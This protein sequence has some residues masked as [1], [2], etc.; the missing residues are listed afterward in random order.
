MRAIISASLLKSKHAQATAKPYD[1]RDTRLPGFILRVQPSGVRSYN[2]ETGRGKRVSVGKVGEYTPDEARD[3]AQRVIGN[4]AHDRP[5]LEGLEGTDAG[6]TLGEFIT[7]TY[8]PWQ[9]ANRP[10]G[11][12]YT[13]EVIRRYFKPWLAEPLSA[14]TV[15]RVEAWKTEK[16]SGGLKPATVLRGLASLSGCLSHA[17]RIGALEDNPLRKVVKPKL[18]RSPKVRYLDEAEEARLRAALAERDQRMRKAR[19]SA[20]TWRRARRQD[21][22]PTLKHFGDHLTPAVLISINTGLRRGELLALKWEDVDAKGKLVTVHGSG[23]KSGQTRHVPLN[24]E[25]LAAFK[26]W[27]QQTGDAERVFPFETTFKSAWAELLARAKIERFRWHDLRHHF[28]SRLA[29]AGVPLN[30]VREL[31]GHGSL[32]MTLR[33]AHLAPDQRR[34]AVDAL[35][36]PKAAASARPSA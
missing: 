4:V 32:A 17:V 25:A 30:T 21:P 8:E 3:R 9:K 24:S 12:T 36:V 5:P 26:R 15:A 33:Y 16:L 6:P 27:Q 18:D 28:A 22:L 13:I 20:N 14:I 2:V 34:A 1:I 31:L 35:T 7:A 23:A 29:Q 11:A 19:R 10:R